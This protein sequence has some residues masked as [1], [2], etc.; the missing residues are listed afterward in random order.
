MRR[1]G[2]RRPLLTT[3]KAYA[4][5]AFVLVDRFYVRQ[6]RLK[7]QVEPEGRDLLAVAVAEPGPIVL[8]GGHCGALEMAM[9]ALEDLGRPVHPVAVADPGAGMLFQGV[10]DP[11][12]DLG[13]GRPAI[14]ADGSVAS[15][16]RMLK[17]LR[18]GEALGFKADRVLPGTAPEECL[19]VDFAGSM[20]HFPSGP[21]KLIGLGKARAVVV[22]A[23]RTGPARFELLADAI[24]VS[25]TEAS[26]LGQAFASLLV[27]HVRRRPDQWFN[28]Y[29]FWPE[30]EAPVAALPRTVPPWFRSAWPASVA[31]VG[32]VL[33]LCMLP[34]GLG[35][36]GRIPAYVL[37]VVVSA[38]GLLVSW[39]RCRALC[40]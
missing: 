9:E 20:A 29:P 2:C 6:G 4:Q 31:I 18:A 28:F 1:L 39:R 12:R 40:H 35:L 15:G 3:F 19:E 38:T 17:V 10:G 37:G 22:S 34:S 36:E 33:A 25:N 27:Q 11:T 14:V 16:L 23:F 32:T 13:F 21:L 5:Y 24:D 26:V 8:L 7:V 30:D